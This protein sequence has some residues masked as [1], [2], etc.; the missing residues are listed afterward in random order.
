MIYVKERLYEVICYNNNQI[1]YK[2]SYSINVQKL[3]SF[4]SENGFLAINV[5]EGD[6]TVIVKYTGTIAMRIAYYISSMTMV[7]IIV[8]FT[9]KLIK[10]HSKK[11]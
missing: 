8:I 9:K 4:E 10:N 7:S 6:I 2:E 11:E 3:Q 1:Q 5:P